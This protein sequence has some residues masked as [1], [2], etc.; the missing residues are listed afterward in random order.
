MPF[1]SVETGQINTA[2]VL[3]ALIGLASSQRP[4]SV[5]WSDQSFG[6]DGPWN[7]VTLRM[8]GGGKVALYAGGWWET[9]L[10]PS[11]YCRDN[12]TTSTCYAEDAG[13][14]HP[15]YSGGFDNTSIELGPSGYEWEDLDYSPT[16]ATPLVGKARRAQ[17]TFQ[18][19]GKEVVDADIIV[20]KEGTQIYPGGQ[21][22]PVQV[23]HLS[24][25]AGEINQTFQ[26]W[27]EI[28]S[29]LVASWLWNGTHE[30]PSY[31]YGMH[32]GSASH[33]IPGS[34]IL[35]GYDKSRALGDISAQPHT[36]N[37]APIQLLEISLGVAA[38]GSPWEFP[39]KSGLLAQGNS[40]LTSGTSVLANVV[41]PYIY[42][43]Q[44]SCDAI[45]AE[46]P[47][48]HNPDLGLY[49]WN[50]DDTQYT[51]IVTSASYLAFTF[52][53]DNTN[54]QNI[55]IRVPFQLLNLT[56]EAPL[57]KKPTR[58]FPCFGT[59][60]TYAL[61]RA[62]FQAAFIGVNYGTGNGIGNWFLAQAPGP[63][64]STSSIIVTEAGATEL[65]GSSDSWAE[66]WTSHWTPLPG[67]TDSTI[68]DSTE[69]SN[70]NSTLPKNPKDEGSSLSLGDRVGIGA[71][72]GAVGLI[73]AVVFGWWL[74][75][76]R[77]QHK[78]TT[79]N[80]DSQKIQEDS[81]SSS[82]SAQELGWE[83]QNSIPELE[84]TQ[85]V[86]ELDHAQTLYELDHKQAIYEVGTHR[87]IQGPFEMG[88]GRNSGWL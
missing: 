13:L 85:Q 22:Y 3:Y 41:D 60:G 79:L 31:S 21:T 81:A 76:R 47:V 78:K 77:K 28:Q 82:R 54:D 7:A 62:F 36:G 8:G 67:S 27:K 88:P 61:G 80:N 23:G 43:P 9:W 25:G 74:M 45:A 64:I 49:L 44:S 19:G 15:E 59:E 69:G 53:K 58:Y 66:T 6:P 26:T 65:T 17:D 51:K 84:H 12:V 14:Y 46:L 71:G 50:T 86:A 1:S 34:L 24:L 29:T 57:V 20:I 5:P 52:I 83:A 87:S 16:G 30:I 48:T 18:I 72:A 70:T 68:K 75:R 32:V 35:G 55:T 10:I 4:L 42:L 40:S 56:L 11:S 39:R 33:N 37:S 73:L 38:G 2:F 63:G